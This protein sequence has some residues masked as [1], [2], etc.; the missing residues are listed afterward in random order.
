MASQLNGPAL[1]EGFLSLNLAKEVCDALEEIYGEGHNLAR[2]YLLQQE[3]SKTIKGDRLF[4]IY[5]GNLKGTS[6]ELAQHSPLLA[7]LEVQK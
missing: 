4:H 3:I 5:L 7:D 2:V 6:D 1:A